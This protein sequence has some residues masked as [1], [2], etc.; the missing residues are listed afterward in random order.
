MNKSRMCFHTSTVAT[1]QAG[2]SGGLSAQQRRANDDG[3]GICCQEPNAWIGE[4]VPP[5]TKNR[6]LDTTNR[7]PMDAAKDG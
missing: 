3:K 6:A 2:T 4:P 5:Q 1:G 7:C